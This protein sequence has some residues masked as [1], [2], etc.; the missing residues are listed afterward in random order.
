[1]DARADAGRHAKAEVA[2]H[3]FKRWGEVQLTGAILS[4]GGYLLNGPGPLWWSLVTSG[5]GL[6]IAGAGWVG[7]RRNRQ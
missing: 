7:Y 4:V 2:V 3:G 6:L 5:I 1:M